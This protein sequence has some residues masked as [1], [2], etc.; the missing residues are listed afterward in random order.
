[1]AAFEVFPVTV[2]GRL[3]GWYWQLRSPEGTRTGPAHG[4]YRSER[5][6]LE[7]AQRQQ[8]CEARRRPRTRIRRVPA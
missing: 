4:P 3:Y 8:R 6:A 5:E 7:D 2:Y 1:M